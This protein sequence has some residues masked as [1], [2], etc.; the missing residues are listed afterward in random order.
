MVIWPAGD[1]PAMRA[2]AR[3]HWPFATSGESTDIL[4][5]AKSWG[6]GHDVRKPRLQFAL[7]GQTH[8]R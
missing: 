2:G 6:F 8:A 5:G 1:A 3:S 4:G 7:S